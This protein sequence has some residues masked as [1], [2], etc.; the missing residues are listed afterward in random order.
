M[1]RHADEAAALLR[2]ALESSGIELE[3]H[4]VLSA[5]EIERRLRAADVLLFVRGGI[6][7]HRGRPI[8]GIVCGL[9]VVAFSGP[10]TGPPLLMRAC[11]SRQRATLKLLPPLFLSF[12]RTTP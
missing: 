12:L 4:G 9:P 5:E 6:S 2:V 3:V 8:A 10:E 1:G 7:S 11:F